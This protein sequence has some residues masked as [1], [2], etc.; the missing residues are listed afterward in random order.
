MKK[1]QSE[2]KIQTQCE[3]FITCVFGELQSA[4]KRACER[5]FIRMNINIAAK[6]KRQDIWGMQISLIY[7]IT[8]ISQGTFDHDKG[9]N[10]RFRGTI[11]TGFF[12]YS[13]VEFFPF[14]SGLMSNLERRSPQNVWLSWLFRPP[15]NVL[16]WGKRSQGGASFSFQR[17]HERLHCMSCLKAPRMPPVAALVLFVLTLV[18]T[19][20]VIGVNM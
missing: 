10:L 16:A 4:C 14:S 5:N 6:R 2:S 1:C 19:I 20:R 9:Q 12:E 11:F 3:S 13:P 7:V 8:T 17:R 15:K 18:A